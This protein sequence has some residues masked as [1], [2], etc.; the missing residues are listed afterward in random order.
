MSNSWILDKRCQCGGESI[1]FPLPGKILALLGYVWEKIPIRAPCCSEA[2]PKAGQN[3]AQSMWKQGRQTLQAG[4][5]GLHPKSGVRY[6]MLLKNC[7]FFTRGISCNQ[8][9]RLCGSIQKGVWLV[10]M[11][12]QSQRELEWA[13]VCLIPQPRPPPQQGLVL[14][15]VLVFTSCLEIRDTWQVGKAGRLNSLLSDCQEIDW[16]ATNGVCLRSWTPVHGKER[17]AT[18]IGK[19]TSI[20]EVCLGGP[21][22]N[23]CRFCQTMWQTSQTLYLHTSVYLYRLIIRQ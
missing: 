21:N 3:S 17:M 4:S 19:D 8:I 7:S 9:Q 16:L 10:T 14:S 2:W 1:F 18:L 5:L 11:C 15:A 23:H 22:F 6:H 12:L 13:C 20:S